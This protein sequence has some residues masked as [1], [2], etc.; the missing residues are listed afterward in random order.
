MTRK[1]KQKFAFV[2]GQREYAVGYCEVKET[3]NEP[4]PVREGSSLAG[5][6][7]RVFTVE[8]VVVTFGLLMLVAVWIWGAK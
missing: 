3:N 2:K 8:N 1:Q 7:S 5:S 4:G 6:A